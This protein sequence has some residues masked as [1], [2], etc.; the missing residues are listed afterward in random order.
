[1]CNTSS[2]PHIITS[3]HQYILLGEIVFLQNKSSQK[4]GANLATV[5][6]PAKSGGHKHRPNAQGH[7]LYRLCFWRGRPPF[8]GG[9][10]FFFFLFSGSTGN[11]VV[12]ID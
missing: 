10:A 6:R 1:V 5:A 11:L 9:M 8:A 2:N 3:T 12:G 7:L 4:K